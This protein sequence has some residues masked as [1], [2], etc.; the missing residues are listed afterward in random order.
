MSSNNGATA[1][2]EY[3][4]NAPAGTG[5][6]ASQNFASLRAQSF[7]LAKTTA[8][9]IL[10]HCT[11]EDCSFCFAGL[12]WNGHSVCA[13]FDFRCDRRECAMIRDRDPGADRNRDTCVT[14]ARLHRERFSRSR[15]E[16]LKHFLRNRQSARSLPKVCFLA[17][18]HRK[19]DPSKLF[20]FRVVQ[21]GLP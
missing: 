1:R 16:N 17:G 13:V 21:P 9:R 7:V 14:R 8:R 4:T 2:G 5:K 10:Q 18:P 19:P 15:G 11:C 12:E 6:F 20:E 3:T